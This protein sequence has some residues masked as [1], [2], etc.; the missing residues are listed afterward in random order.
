MRNLSQLCMF[1]SISPTSRVGAVEKYCNILMSM[2]DMMYLETSLTHSFQDSVAITAS[3][4]LNHTPISNGQKTPLELWIGYTYNLEHL[5]VWGC[6][7]YPHVNDEDEYD[8]DMERCF[9]IGYPRGEKGYLLW[10]KSTDE[11]VTC[12]KGGLL[13]VTREYEEDEETEA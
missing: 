5:H 2:V 9:L 10:R 13:K 4:I 1:S 11:I 6:E 8:K 3:Y 7:V 12:R